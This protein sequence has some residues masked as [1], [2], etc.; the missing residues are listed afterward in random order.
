M[1]VKNPSLLAQHEAVGPRHCPSNNDGLAPKSKFR[2][3]EK[4]YDPQGK[5]PELDVDGPS[6]RSTESRIHRKA[7]RPILSLGDVL[8]FQFVNLFEFGLNHYQFLFGSEHFM[9]ALLNGMAFHPY[10]R[11][12]EFQG[13][14]R[15]G[16]LA[17]NA[18]DLSL[19]IRSTSAVSRRNFDVIDQALTRYLQAKDVRVV[20]MKC[21]YGEEYG[22]AGTGILRCD[23][24]TN[25]KSA[26]RRHSIFS[27]MQAIKRERDT[28]V[29]DTK[30]ED[31][32]R[33]LQ[34]LDRN[35][36]DGGLAKTDRYWEW[37]K[38]TK[39]LSNVP[40]MRYFQAM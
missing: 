15:K 5:V 38:W 17:V 31:F 16:N 14:G 9:V 32:E 39:K 1:T 23:V 18:L 33:V 19:V 3:I 29:V 34:A 6:Q 36:R 21:L 24:R 8:R 35:W 20:V 10:L 4:L 30:L 26:H 22:S 7:T 12:V 37:K 40:K 27:A 13:I 28:K 11:S 25:K 2:P